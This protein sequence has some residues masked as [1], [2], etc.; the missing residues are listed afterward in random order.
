MYY[1]FL[2]ERH[3]AKF[4]QFDWSILSVSEKLMVC[5]QQRV[6]VDNRIN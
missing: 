6:F 3:T 5:Y 1:V 2:R 4:A